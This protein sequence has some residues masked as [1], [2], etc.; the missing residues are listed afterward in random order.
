MNITEI[1][2]ILFLIMA[3]IVIFSALIVVFKNLFKS[4][5]NLNLGE[6]EL[7][8]NKTKVTIQCP[9]CGDIYTINKIDMAGN[10]RG[11]TTV[12]CYK[13]NYEYRQINAIINEE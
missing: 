13:C 9:K 12:R 7:D 6:D 1:F 4:S 8:S 2:S 10:G 5:E 3:T 11:T